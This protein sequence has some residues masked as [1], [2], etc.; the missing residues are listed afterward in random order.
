MFHANIKNLFR[1]TF[2]YSHTVDLKGCIVK[3]D[4]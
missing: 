2:S 1:V 3:A 4:A